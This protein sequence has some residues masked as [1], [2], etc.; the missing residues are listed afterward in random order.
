MSWFVTFTISQ[1]Y[2]YRTYEFVIKI[3]EKPC[4]IHE[5]WIRIRNTALIAFLCWHQRWLFNLE[6][7]LKT[8]PH[9]ENR[10]LYLTV[11]KV[12]DEGGTA[13]S[14][15]F[16]L[17][18]N[19]KSKVQI[20]PVHAQLKP[21]FQIRNRL[22]KDPD[23]AFKV[24]TDPDADQAFK[25][26]TDPDA[27]KAQNAIRIRLMFL[28]YQHLSSKICSGADPEPEPEGSKT[29]GRIRIR[30]SSEINI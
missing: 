18:I 25:F 7:V 2:R 17:Q 27:N 28:F 1:R 4:K 19:E 3:W 13:T 26:Y 12:D 23:P 21:L 6:T 11:W 22:N 15:N 9:V 30:S 29:F 20:I 8:M 5:Y 10:Q 16:L 14:T 24:N